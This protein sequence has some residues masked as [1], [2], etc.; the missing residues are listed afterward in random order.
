[1]QSDIED[2]CKW[3]L[4]DQRRV[5]TWAKNQRQSILESDSAILL[6]QSTQEVLCEANHIISSNQMRKISKWQVRSREKLLIDKGCSSKQFFRSLHASHQ[7][8]SIFRIKVSDGSWTSSS[9]QLS[10]ECVQHYAQLFATPAPL[11][12]AESCIRQQFLDVVSPIM[13]FDE[14]NALEKHFT[15]AELDSVLKS[16]GKGKAPGWD[17]FTVELFHAFW[18]E[19]KHVLLLM[20]N[21]A[22]QEQQL[23]SLWKQGL[24]KLLPKSLWLNLLMIDDQSLL[25]Q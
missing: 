23:P 6:D 22:W 7:K 3:F 8:Q 17:G 20:I 13:A 4:G 10:Q 19:L 14:A 24:L 9:L 2:F 12:V 5:L 15:E 18:N 11:S 21:R 16:L 1:M 25:C